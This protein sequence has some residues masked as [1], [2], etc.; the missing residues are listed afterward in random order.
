MMYRL[1][2]N[3]QLIAKPKSEPAF[4]DALCDEFDVLKNMAGLE[5]D[6]EE[7]ETWTCPAAPRTTTT[8]ATATTRPSPPRS[9]SARSAA[10]PE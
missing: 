4:V 9:A 1:F 6:D 2:P 7:D 5:G 3:G 8:W 10:P